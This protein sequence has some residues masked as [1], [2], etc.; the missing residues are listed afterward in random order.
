MDNQQHIFGNSG[1]FQSNSI[2][3]NEGVYQMNPSLSIN[4]VNEVNP[5]EISQSIPQQQPVF[6]NESYPNMS[7]SVASNP[8]PGQQSYNMQPNTQQISFS[9]PVLSNQHQTQQQNMTMQAVSNQSY[10]DNHSNTHLSNPISNMLSFQPLPQQQTANINTIQH[11]LSQQSQTSGNQMNFQ[12]NFQASTPPPLSQLQG[13]TV[14]SQQ[15]QP[16]QT[17]SH[18]PPTTMADPID[19]SQ[20]FKTP[21]TSKA[22]KSRS[23]KKKASSQISTPSNKPTETS[24]GTLAFTDSSLSNS[25]VA[26]PQSSSTTNQ[27]STS[28]PKLKDLVGRLLSCTLDAFTDKDFGEKTLMNLARKLSSSN[29]MESVSVLQ[30]WENAIQKC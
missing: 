25:P 7:A 6:Y 13:V 16:P 22:P 11:N 12:P 18:V 8:A 1:N 14:Y 15:Q 27:T 30:V 23:P 10:Q 4:P 5:G 2:N 24:T 17:I 20:T 26:S 9:Q 3:M 28:F 21:T 19:N 29:T